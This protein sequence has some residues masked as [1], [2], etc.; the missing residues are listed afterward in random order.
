LLLTTF[1]PQQTEITQ[2]IFGRPLNIHANI[3]GI[4]ISGLVKNGKIVSPLFRDFAATAGNVMYVGP[5]QQ[6]GG[7]DTGQPVNIGIINPTFVRTVVAVGGVA[8]LRLLG[9]ATNYATGININSSVTYPY[10]VDV[11]TGGT[12]IQG[13]L[14]PGS[15]GLANVHGTFPQITNTVGGQSLRR[16]RLRRRAAR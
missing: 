9:S 12:V 5:S 16:G 15:V 14:L 3:G 8:P 1:V 11:D 10:A 7:V 4:T 6:A 2:F 13:T